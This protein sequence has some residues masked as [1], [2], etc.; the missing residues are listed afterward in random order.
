MIA[1]DE[2]D[3]NTARIE[4]KEASQQNPYNLYRIALAYQG[5]GDTKNAEAYFKRAA[6]FNG[7][8]NINQAFVRNIMRK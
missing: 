2:K 6:N 3:F 4:L 5:Q 8:N 1:L 7:L